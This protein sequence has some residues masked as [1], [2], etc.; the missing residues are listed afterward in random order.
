MSVILAVPAIWQ[1]SK[2]WDI[3]IFD[4]ITL[5]SN[6][7]QSRRVLSDDPRIGVGKFSRVKSPIGFHDE[8]TALRC[9]F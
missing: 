6:R 2:L 4:R 7:N 5:S 3:V 9:D 1:L 8:N